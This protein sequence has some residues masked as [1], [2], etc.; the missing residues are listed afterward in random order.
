MRVLC[1]GDIHIGPSRYLWVKEQ[2][3]KLLDWVLGKVKEWECERVVFLGDAFRDRMHSGKDKDKVWFLFRELAKKVDVV[4]VAGNHDYYDKACEESGLEVLKGLEGVQVVDMEVYK[5]EVSGREI[6]YVP[7][8]W[9]V[10]EIRSR[11]EGDVVF[12]HFELR[13][14]VVW[15]GEE[16]VSLD[17]FEG[18]RLVIS[19]HI[20]KRQAVG[21]VVYAGVPFQR[22]FADGVEVG[23]VVVD[24]DFLR[25]EWVDGYGVRFVQVDRIEDLE[26]LDVRNC[27]VRVRDKDLVGKVRELGVVGVEYLPDVARGY[28]G[29]VR[30]FQLESVKVDVWKMLEEYG[31]KVLKMGEKE[32]QWLKSL[33]KN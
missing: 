30:L 7:W 10:Q 1:F 25:W 22:N 11:L 23:G 17:D 16:Q 29:G 9:C 33:V 2:E 3:D 6:V 15:E 19:G 26:I 4:V 18:V 5:E 20:H 14:A 13:E 31:R 32:V 24:L 21:K 12:G 8:R 28:D 27:Y